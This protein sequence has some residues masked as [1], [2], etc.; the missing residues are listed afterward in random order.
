MWMW[1]WAAAMAAEPSEQPEEA[2][3]RFFMPEIEVGVIWSGDPDISPGLTFRTSVEWRLRRIQAPFARFSYDSTNARIVRRDLGEV[4]SLTAGLATH[5]LIA[6]GGMR[7]GPPA[8]QGTASLQGGVQITGLPELQGDEADLVIGQR[9]RWSG[10]LVG[11]LGV[12]WYFNQRTALTV[13]STGR[14][15][16]GRDIGTRALGAGFTVGVTTEL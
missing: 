16:I 10:V 2:R 3:E 1:M 12:E 9:T 4:V 7:F 14:V 11:G 5:D 8:L 6:G 13:E 15:L